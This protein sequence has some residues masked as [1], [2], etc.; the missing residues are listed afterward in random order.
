M[1]EHFGRDAGAAVGNR[2]QHAAI[3]GGIGCFERN[4]ALLLFA[5]RVERIAEQIDDHLL[6]LARLRTYQRARRDS[7][8]DLHGLVADSRIVDKPRVRHRF[9]E[10]H[11]HALDNRLARKRFQFAGERGHVVDETRH[12]LK[13]RDRVRRLIAFEKRARVI[14]QRA[15]RDERLT[16]LVR[17][18]RS[19]LAEHREL[20]RMHDFLL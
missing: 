5:D 7:H 9:V 16:Q 15:D 14:A 20:A 2:E 6:Q 8:V 3:V 18:T 10:R 17:E 13:I 1:L 11:G 12:A 4:H 19:H